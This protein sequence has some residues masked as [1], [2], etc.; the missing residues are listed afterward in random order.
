MPKVITVLKLD[1]LSVVDDP[2]N[3]DARVSIFKRAGTSVPEVKSVEKEDPVTEKKEDT[4]IEK[5]EE[6]KVEEQIVALTKS[7]KD[8][9]DQLALY[10]KI[11]GLGT[12]E[13]TFYK[14][15]DEAG[16]TKFLEAD[17]KVR[18]EL[19]SEDETLEIAGVL[20]RKS[21]IGSAQFAVIKHQQA[22]IT[23]QQTD[24]AKA[25]EEAELATVTKRVTEEFSHVVGKTEEKA[26]LLQAVAK[27]GN[28]T[29]KKALDAVLRAT[30]A[31]VK[32]GFDKAGHGGAADT[33]VS[34]K[35]IDFMAKVQEIKAAEKCAAHEAMSKARQKFPELHREAFPEEQA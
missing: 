5:K 35:R 9:T 16:R 14:K 13:L 34:K 20:L 21:E 17:A 28:E 11:D 1:E 3:K 31:M 12:E 18:K 19:M 27:A 26:A 33:D 2:A 15:L 29:A 30:E 7:L 23:Q 10:K 4:K 22:Q 24:L 25:R 32:Q 6:P 8:V